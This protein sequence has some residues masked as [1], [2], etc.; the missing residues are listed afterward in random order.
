M[1]IVQVKSV[2]AKKDFVGAS[3]TADLPLLMAT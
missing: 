1:A 2:L 3:F